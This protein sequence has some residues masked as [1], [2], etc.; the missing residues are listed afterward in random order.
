MPALRHP[1]DRIWVCV[2]CGEPWELPADQEP[3]RSMLGPICEDCAG[4]PFT[5]APKPLEVPDI[6]LW[7]RA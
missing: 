2:S 1:S 5:P 4:E 3:R 6:S 7:R